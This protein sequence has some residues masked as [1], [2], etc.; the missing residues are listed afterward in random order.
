MIDATG[1]FAPLVTPFTDDQS[2][3]SE[4]RLS[5]MMRKLAANGVEGFVIASNAG[6]FACIT[7]LERKHLLEL[8]MRENVNG[9][10][11]LVNVSTLSSNVALDLAQHAKRHGARGIL[12][13]PPYYGNYSQQEIAIHFRFIANHSGLP[14]LRFV[15]DNMYGMIDED[16]LKDHAGIRYAAPIETEDLIWSNPNLDEFKFGDLLCSPMENLRLFGEVEPDQKP[17]FVQAFR[18][19]GTTRVMKALGILLDFELGPPRCPVQPMPHEVAADL[20]KRFSKVE[21]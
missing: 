15:L 19:Y 18:T 21:V 20:S 11:V 2:T 12:A 16:L 5:R 3:I 14:L 4:V 9:L 13:I 8:G 6:E 7:V 17:A 10:P 1:R